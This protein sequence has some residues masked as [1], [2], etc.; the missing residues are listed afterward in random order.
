MQS[1]HGIAML[2]SMTGS[3][4]VDEEKRMHRSRLA[5]GNLAVAGLAVASLALGAVLIPSSAGAAPFKRGDLFAGDSIKQSDKDRGFFGGVGFQIAPVK[6]VIQSQV[7]AKVDGISGDSAEAAMVKEIVGDLDTDQLRALAN[8]GQLDQFKDMLKEE[9]KANGSLDPES[10]ALIDGLSENQLRLMADLVDMYNAP[11]ETL[12]FGLEPYVGYNWAWVS[13]SATLPLAGFKNDLSSE[14]G[15]S[16][17][18]LGNASLDLRLG[19]SYGEP[20]AA[21]GWT[22]GVRGYGPSAGADANAVALS[23]PLATPKYLHEYASAQPYFAVGMDFAV[24]EVT[25]RASYTYMQAVRDMD[26][27]ALDDR[28]LGYLTTGAAARLNFGFASL[29][30]ELDGV[31]E[32]GMRSP[33]GNAFLATLGTRTFLGP[34][35]LGAAL[36]VP[37]SLGASDDASVK[38]GGVSVGSIAS[39]NIL[40]DAKVSF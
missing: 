6:A 37:W 35:H 10:E 20:G 40:V 26:A 33:L 12:T 38:M 25:L 21:F 14:L 2:P 16:V 1:W 23:N 4:P 13:V 31:I 18:Q 27:I 11:P 32:A 15:T 5:L 9:L 34:V 7:K 22:F 8:S 39:Y 30:A 24:V 29:S 17:L 28:K 3:G 36:Q 19:H